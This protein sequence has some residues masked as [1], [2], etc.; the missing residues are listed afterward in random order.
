MICHLNK[1][2]DLTICLIY[3]KKR[4]EIIKIVYIKLG[5]LQL[6][7][8]ITEPLAIFIVKNQI[9][10]LNHIIYTKEVIRAFLT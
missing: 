4:V 7:I 9:H 8:V 1:R 10:Y 6:S 3:A 5:L 2:Y